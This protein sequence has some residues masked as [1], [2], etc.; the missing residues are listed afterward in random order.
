MVIERV[1]K[2][3]G[4]PKLSKVAESLDKF[5]DAKNLRLVKDVLIAAEKVSES[6]PQLDLVI[7]L[8]REINSMPTEKLE[9]LEKVLKSIERILKKAPD[10]LMKFLMDLKEE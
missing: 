4:L 7:S 6:A 1:E 3:F 2:T 9:K 8:I 10:D 5:P